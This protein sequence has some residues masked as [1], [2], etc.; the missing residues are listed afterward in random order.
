MRSDTCSVREPQ[1]FTHE[2]F[3]SLHRREPHLGGLG[4]REGVGLGLE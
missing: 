2:R 3:A 4:A 1:D